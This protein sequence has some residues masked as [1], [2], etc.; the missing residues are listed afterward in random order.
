MG[1]F[2]RKQSL[3]IFSIFLP[4]RISRNFRVK[5]LFLSILLS[6]FIGNSSLF[7]KAPEP[8]SYDL[9]CLADAGSLAPDCS[10]GEFCLVAGVVDISAHTTANPVLPTGFEILYILTRGSG[11]LIMD[12]SSRASFS[13]SRTGS[14]AIHTL[15]HNPDSQSPDYLNLAGIST[16]QTTL[17][18]LNNEIASQGICADLDVTGALIRVRKCLIPFLIQARDDFMNTLLDIP[19]EGNVLNNDNLETGV[20]YELSLISGPFNGTLALN[21]DGSVVYIPDPGFVGRDEFTYRVCD[22]SFCPARCVQATDYI[23]VINP[24]PLNN[25]PIANLDAACVP[26]DNSINIAVLSNDIDQDGDALQNPMPVSP[27]SNGTLTYESD[28]TITYTPT[29]GFSGY[30]AFEYQVCDTGNPSLCDI[31]FVTIRVKST[32]GGGNPPIPMD[33]AI[34]MPINTGRYG[35]TVIDNDREPDGDAITYSLFE[36]PAHGTLSFLPDGTYDYVPDFDYVGPDYFVYTMTDKDGSAR[37]SVII[38]VYGPGISFPV[39]W[40]SIAASLE[41]EDAR[42]FWETAS[43]LNADRFEIERS[44]GQGVKFERIGEIQAKGNSTQVSAYTF[45]DKQVLDLGVDKLF[46][47]LKQLDVDGSFTYSRTFELELGNIPR[48]SLQ[49]APNPVE[50]QVRITWT[51]TE[52]VYHIRILN[53][54]GESVEEW[55]F[56]QSS[57]FGSFEW[58]L[59]HLPAGIYVVQ[60]NSDHAQ[61]EQKILIR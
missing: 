16:G 26:Q 59:D 61:A 25:P 35:Q 52:D 6:C 43:E 12:T 17:A 18:M 7:A 22:N 51:S 8:L 53:L 19:V 58:N 15:V 9:L 48:I 10:N 4:E 50:D 37:A 54:F 42:L 30:D 14:Y 34:T 2:I 39:E 20:V 47:R 38:T 21:P 49:I 24:L 60:S 56:A 33:D 36:G 41:Q 3:I 46:Y 40:L 23:V 32:A 55:N 13:V 31:G 44:T 11:Q 28:G 27:P 29:L 57:R 45:L 1:T 5:S